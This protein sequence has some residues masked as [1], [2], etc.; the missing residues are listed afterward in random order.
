V[1]VKLVLLVTVVGLPP[2]STSVTLSPTAICATVPPTENELVAH[3]TTT[4]E[5]FALVTGPVPAVTVQV[6]EMG[7]DGL[8]AVTL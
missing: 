5:M 7:D 3:V 2:L 8:A 1:N 4:L 6:C